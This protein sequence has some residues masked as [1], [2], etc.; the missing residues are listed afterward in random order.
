MDFA[1]GRG[2]SNTGAEMVVKH[3][4]TG[5][6]TDAKIRLAG[7]DSDVFKK[8]SRDMR[9]RVAKKIDEGDAWAGV[10]VA[11]T[12]GWSGVELEGKSYAFSPSNAKS[13][14]SA[15]PWLADQV[16]RFI[17][18]RGHFYSPCASS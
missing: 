11:C 5:E 13:L 12:L 16:E 1:I 18:D 4:G 2:D 17:S 10:L 8:A 15:C 9:D 3:P 7:M 6:K 14:Y